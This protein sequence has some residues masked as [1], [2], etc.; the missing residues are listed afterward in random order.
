MTPFEL[1]SRIGLRLLPAILLASSMFLVGAT[2]YYTPV[3]PS[4]PTSHS[5]PLQGQPGTTGPMAGE[6]S[7]PV[8]S[9]TAFAPFLH[10]VPNDG[11]SLF[12]SAGSEEVGG[13][14]WA[15][16]S[17]IGG[18]NHKGGTMSYSSTDQAYSITMLHPDLMPFQSQEGNVLITTTLGLNTGEANFSRAY[19]PAGDVTSITSPDNILQLTWVHPGAFP[20]ETYVAVVRSYAP[21]DPAPAS[22]RLVSS[23]YSVRASGAQTATARSMLLQL[24]YST[25]QL[26]GADPQDL[27]IFAWVSKQGWDYLGGQVSEEQQY[28][29]APTSRFA[30]YALMV[31]EPGVYLPVVLK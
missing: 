23:A 30:T 20:V 31:K 2:W 14:V 26:M 21:P 9:N 15:D 19:I 13:T 22:Y 4:I 18:G 5:S 12:I 8:I 25:E 6:D 17:I 27:A 24:G 11:S 29:S 16:V 3:S 7:A 1:A 28:V 10:V